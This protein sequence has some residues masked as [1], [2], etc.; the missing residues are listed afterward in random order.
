M[1]TADVSGQVVLG[2]PDWT[3]ERT[4]ATAERVD[5]TIELWP[6]LRREL[7]I[8]TA[9]LVGTVLTF[10]RDAKRR[11]NWQFESR[12]RLAGAK[13]MQI[14][15]LTVENGELRVNDQP[16]RTALVVK[17]TSQKAASD[18][19][20]APHVLAIEGSGR[21]RGEAFELEGKVESP[22]PCAIAATVPDEPGRAGWH[23]RAKLRGARRSVPAQEL[24]A[25]FALSGETLPTYIHC[26]ASCCR[27]R[28]RMNWP[29]AG[30]NDDSGATRSQGRV[31]DSDL[32][33]TIDVDRAAIVHRSA[34]H[35]YRASSTSTIWQDSSARRRRR[36][37]MKRLRPS[38]KG[39]QR[40]C[41]RASAS[42]RSGSTS[43][44]SCAQWMWT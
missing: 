40:S 6:L 23:T 1:A 42:S 33:G 14:G 41:S 5:I 30:A 11:A 4:M 31:G 26:S 37:E 7:V 28:H 24:D 39:S 15:A 22:L 17:V 27:L 3:K 35:W 2:N 25:H 12:S 8:P 32:A 19:D 21:F 10:E 43:S 16:L 36:A 13:P 20:D 9:H 29:H 18:G 38:R 44:T 34:A